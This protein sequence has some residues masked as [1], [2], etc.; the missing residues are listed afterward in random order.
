[1]RWRSTLALSVCL[2]SAA[3]AQDPAVSRAPETFKP[4]RTFHVPRGLIG[5]AALPVAELLRRRAVRAS[6]SVKPR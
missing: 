5:L 1:M 3:L 4:A 6:Q 2:A